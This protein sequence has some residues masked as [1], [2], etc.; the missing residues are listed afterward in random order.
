MS[1]V[2]MS[3]EQRA[4]LETAQRQSQHGRDWKRFQAVRLPVRLRA[5]GMPVVGVGQPLRCS[6][7]SGSNWTTAWRAAGV[8]GVR[9]GLHRGAVRR[10][11]PV[12]A[13]RL[14]EFLSRDPQAAG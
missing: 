7:A 12:G 6:Q 5:E 2:E 9:E 10:V 4:E 13:Q 11:D 1:R 8:A 3:A 14:V